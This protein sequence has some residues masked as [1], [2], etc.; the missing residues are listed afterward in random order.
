MI[1]KDKVKADILRK[2]Q[3]ILV[4]S[5]LYYRFDTNLIE[6]YQYD[7]IGKSLAELQMRYPELSKEVEYKYKAFE[8]FGQ[9]GCYSGYN[10]PTSDPD[11]V[12]KAQRLMDM[13]TSKVIK[14]IKKDY[15]KQVIDII[16]KGVINEVDIHNAIRR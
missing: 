2:R 6:D 13:D 15:I 10:L 4:H 16:N 14:E 9:D 11:V 3:Q 1:D 8:T 7:R 5:C 12:R